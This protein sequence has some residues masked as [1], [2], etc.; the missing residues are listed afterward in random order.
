M[1]AFDVD[2][3]DLNALA[4][5]GLVSAVTEDK[6]IA[7]VGALMLCLP[8]VV[9]AAVVFSLFGAGLA[10][11]AGTFAAAGALAMLGA[12]RGVCL[13]LP[14]EAVGSLRLKCDGCD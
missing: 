7:E 12:E 6:R 8:S 10:L 5:V 2:G 3:I 9:G 1:A 4:G 11:A 13:G 14:T